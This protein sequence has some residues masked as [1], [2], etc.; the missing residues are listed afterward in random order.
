MAVST[1][2]KRAVSIIIGFCAICALLIFLLIRGN[3]DA[4]ELKRMRAFGI[5]NFNETQLRIWKECL[6]VDAALSVAR[7]RITEIEAA[8]DYTD[9]RWGAVEHVA[10]PQVCSELRRMAAQHFSDRVEQERS[11]R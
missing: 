3:I 9:A 1:A 2:D 5:E 11:G 7:K 8:D 10:T 4:F 6:A